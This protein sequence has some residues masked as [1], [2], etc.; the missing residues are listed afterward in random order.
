M[1]INVQYIVCFI[2]N[3]GG[4]TLCYS[5]VCAIFGIRML[6]SYVDSR[7]VAETIALLEFCGTHKSNE[8]LFHSWNPEMSSFVVLI[9]IF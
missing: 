6:Y 8:L 7:T 2:V 3:N 4:V 9:V 1:L 5:R